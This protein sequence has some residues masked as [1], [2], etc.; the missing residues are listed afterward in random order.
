MT[1]VSAVTEKIKEESAFL[2]DVI[3]EVE[4]VIVGQS[5]LIEGMLIGLLADGNLFGLVY[6]PYCWAD[7][8]LVSIA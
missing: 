2:R 6:S 3:R 1:D 5:D 7:L 4:S 8:Q